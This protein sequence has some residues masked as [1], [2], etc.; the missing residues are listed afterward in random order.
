MVSHLSE[1]EFEI[2]FPN[3]FGKNTHHLTFNA[4]W[5]SICSGQPTQKG[6]LNTTAPWHICA[7]ESLF[8]KKKKNV[9]SQL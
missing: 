7:F 4:D 3:W 6:I 8:K 9:Y 5:R 2:S 1:K